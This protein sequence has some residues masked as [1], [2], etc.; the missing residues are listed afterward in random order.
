[1]QHVLLRLYQFCASFVRKLAQLKRW[2]INQNYM[3]CQLCHFF[4]K[5]RTENTSSP[6]FFYI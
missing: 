1:M 4:Y 2:Y 6:V 5:L 3:L